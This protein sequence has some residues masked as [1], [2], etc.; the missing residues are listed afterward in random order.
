MDEIVEAWLDRRCPECGA[1]AHDCRSD[2]CNP[3]RRQDMWVE[4]LLGGRLRFQLTP[5]EAGARREYWSAVH[6]RWVALYL[7]NA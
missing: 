6:G 4:A 3:E 7:H 1:S 5:D 2:G